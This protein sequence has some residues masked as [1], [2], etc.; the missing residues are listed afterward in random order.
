MKTE[1]LYSS[2]HNS[3]MKNQLLKKRRQTFTQYTTSSETKEEFL[4]RQKDYDKLY[5][6]SYNVEQIPKNIKQKHHSNGA[7]EIT[8]QIIEKRENY[9]KYFLYKDHQLEHQQRSIEIIAE[10][11]RK[12]KKL[13]TDKQIPIENKGKQYN[14]IMILVI[15]FPILCI[16]TVMAEL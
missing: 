1:C 7:N 9:G 3:L 12:Q 15:V 11:L 2:N 4:N 6:Y 14:L 5:K 8:Q 10:L 16:L 13:I